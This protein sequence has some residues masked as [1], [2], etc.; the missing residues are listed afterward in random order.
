MKFEELDSLLQNSLSELKFT[1][2]NPLQESIIQKMKQGRNCLIQHQKQEG[3]RTALQFISVMKA[4]QAFEGSP[5]VL[6]ITPTAEKARRIVSELQSWVRRTEIAVELADDKG[7]IIEQRNHIFEGADIIVGNPKRVL[8]LYNQNGIHVNQ[9]TLLLVDDASEL[10]KNP[11]I[12]QHI[13]RVNE[14]LPKCLKMIATTQQ[15]ERLSGFAQDICTF[16]D[17]L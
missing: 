1:A 2:F 10:C 13:K 3:V 4:P 7:K 9:L 8:E 16:Y 12:L 6:W 14:S 15:H 11:V 17:E 5:R